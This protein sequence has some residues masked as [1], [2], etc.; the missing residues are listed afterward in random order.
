[1]I[2]GLGNPGDCF[3]GTRHNVGVE[4]VALLAQ[5]CGQVL[6]KTSEAALVA[7]AKV[8]ER[9]VVLAFPQT[10]MNKSGESVRLLV[11]RWNIAGCLERLVVVHDELDLPPGCIRI[12]YGGGLAGH[13]GLISIRTHLRSAEFT[14]IRIGV[15]KPS[16]TGTLSAG[17]GADYVLQHP[18]RADREMLDDAVARSAEAA[19]ALLDEPL[20]AVMNKFN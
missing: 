13:N 19:L 2:V 10:F 8:D 17:T 7:E 11:R 12:K 14:R 6:R 20:D 18:G 15:G 1:M 3:V 5:R 4:V 16:S 9:R